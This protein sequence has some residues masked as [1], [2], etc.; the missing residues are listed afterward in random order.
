MH[1]ISHIALLIGAIMLFYPVSACNAET[2]DF[3]KQVYPLLKQHCLRCHAAPYTDARS[4]RLKKPKGGIRLDTI[5]S[6]KEG[7]L[8][9]DDK[10][11]MLFVPG[12]PEAS[13]LYTSTALPPDHDDIMPATGE[14]LTLK[15]QALIKNWILG[16]AK[17]NGFEPPNYTNPKAKK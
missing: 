16:G 1:P 3:G 8:D 6:L 7:Y 5:K 17:F 14:P 15:E 12:K 9:D 13:P 4:G 11:K 2:P 10:Q